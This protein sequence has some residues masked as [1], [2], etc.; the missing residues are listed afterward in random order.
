[1]LDVLEKMFFLALG[2]LSCFAALLFAAFT[3][4]VACL[5]FHSWFDKEFALKDRCWITALFSLVITWG[6]Y[7]TYLAGSYGSH[8][9]TGL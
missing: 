1:M 4:M 3:F 9:L 8:W 7:L 2:G 6:G 5:L